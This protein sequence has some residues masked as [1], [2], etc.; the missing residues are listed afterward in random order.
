MRTLEVLLSRFARIVLLA[1]IA[2]SVIPATATASSQHQRETA[3]LGRMWTTIFETPSPQNPFGTGD[4]A[5]ACIQLDKDAIAPFGPQVVPSCTV[6]PGTKI[7]V[8]AY[9]FECSTIEGYGKTYR[10][11]LDCARR[12]DATAATVSVDGRPV[13]V[14]AVATGPLFVVLPADNIFSA[15]AGTSG[16]SVAH[17]WVTLVRPLPPGTHII[18]FWTTKGSGTTTIVVTPQR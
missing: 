3:Y 10:Q 16:I 11:L 7:V 13:S 2:L 12:N 9:S 5:T 8:A 14:S 18:A 17:G 6:K 15:A 1:A 4:A